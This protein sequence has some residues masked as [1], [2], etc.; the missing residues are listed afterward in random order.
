MRK[1]TF[2]LLAGYL[3][4]TACSSDNIKTLHPESEPTDSISQP[5]LE[6]YASPNGILI[7]NG[8]ARMLE[9]GSLS[10]IAPDGTVETN[11]YKK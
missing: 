1:T 9:N 11:V 4:F 3:C 10:Y 2:F 5:A 6:G 8:G 7:L